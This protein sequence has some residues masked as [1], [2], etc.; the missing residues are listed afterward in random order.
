MW[1]RRIKMPLLLNAPLLEAGFV[2]KVIAFL[3]F[4]LVLRNIVWVAAVAAPLSCAH[5]S[6]DFCLWSKRRICCFKPHMWIS[7]LNS[8]WLTLFP[9]YFLPGGVC[10]ESALKKTFSHALRVNRRVELIL[11]LWCSATDALNIF[12]DFCLLL[13][14]RWT[15]K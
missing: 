10:I 15:S 11:E 12:G 9:C 14:R 6:I 7:F 5:A 2:W 8:Y 13:V 3:N 4:C 1:K